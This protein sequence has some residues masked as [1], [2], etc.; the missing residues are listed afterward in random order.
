MLVVVSPL[1]VHRGGDRPVTRTPWLTSRHSFSFGPHYDP[2]N[3]HFGMLVSHN[4]DI[5]QPGTGF[6]MHAH[7]GLEIVTWVLSG[8]L[9]HRDSDG[10]AGHVEPGTVQVMTAGTGIAHSEVA[11][12][13]GP[14]HYVQMWVVAGTDQVPDYRRATI[15]AS[16]GELVPVASGLPEHSGLVPI[17]ISQPAAGFSVAQLR[18]GQNLR[19]PDALF[20]HVFVAA[21]SVVDDDAAV[22]MSA[23]DALRLSGPDSV[24]VTA[25]EQA[26]LLVWVMRASVTDERR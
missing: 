3:T 21:G 8:R 18:P 17:A 13:D 23:G 24:E 1:D 19:L 14:A 5:L 2:C 7:H 16:E 12:A 25:T 11:A 6:D 15:P 9:E 22:E 26:Q 4:E 10:R 20:V